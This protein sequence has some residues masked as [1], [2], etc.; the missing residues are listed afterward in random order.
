VSGQLVRYRFTVDEYEQMVSTGL[1]DEDAKIELIDGAI[2]EMA[3]IGDDHVSGLNLLVDDLYEQVR[4]QAIVS[5]QNPIR[6]PPYGEPQPDIALIRRAAARRGVPR[7]EDIILVMEIADS[8]IDTDRK[9][10][11]PLYAAA[12]IPEAWLADMKARVI[13]RHTDPIDG[14]YRQVASARRG[15]SLASTVLPNLTIRAS[16]NFE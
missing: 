1:F 6:I 15:Q 12:G 7:I 16:L 13:E 2:V 14:N 10:K 5:V 9:V 3:P 8:T 11:L 4:G